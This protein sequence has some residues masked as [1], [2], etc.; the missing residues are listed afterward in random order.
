MDAVNTCPS[1]VNLYSIRGRFH[2]MIFC[3]KF[4]FFLSNCIIKLKS[5]NVDAFKENYR[6]LKPNA[7]GIRIILG[8]VKV[9]EVGPNGSVHLSVVISLL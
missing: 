3:L 5:N 1:S 4:R 6:I 7:I 2:Y 8:L 9:K